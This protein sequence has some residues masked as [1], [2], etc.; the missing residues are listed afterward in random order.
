VAA[1]NARRSQTDDRREPEVVAAVYA[2]T[3]CWNPNAR[4]PSGS[5]G[6]QSG[7]EVTATTRLRV[8]LGF[9]EENGAGQS[10]PDLSTAVSVAI[11][12]GEGRLAGSWLASSLGMPCGVVPVGFWSGL[13]PS[14]GTSV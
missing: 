10:S 8:Q 13:A 3:V 4:S 1:W 5:P 7:A 6:A 11:R 12:S 2:P 9:S 14:A